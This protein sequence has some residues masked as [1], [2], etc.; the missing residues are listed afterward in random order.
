MAYMLMSEQLPYGMCD[1]NK[2][3]IGSINLAN[4]SF[5]S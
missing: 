3:T 2:E 1:R 4:C 5:F